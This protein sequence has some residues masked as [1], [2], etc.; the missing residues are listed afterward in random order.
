MVIHNS[1]HTLIIL[2]TKCHNSIKGLLPVVPQVHQ[3]QVMDLHQ[4]QG[5]MASR[6]LDIQGILLLSHKAR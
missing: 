2:I 5:P 6:T 4:V 3:G 1:S